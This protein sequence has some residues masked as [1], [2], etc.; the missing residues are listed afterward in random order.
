M[1]LTVQFIDNSNNRKKKILGVCNID[2]DTSNFKNVQN[3][4]VQALKQLL[5]NKFNGNAAN[6]LQKAT[7]IVQVQN[8]DMILLSVDDNRNNMGKIENTI[9]VELGKGVLN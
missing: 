6:L 7:E 1:I 8:P 5:K 9:R 2:I 3:C 4:Y